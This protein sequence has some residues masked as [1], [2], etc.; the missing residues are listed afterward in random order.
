[1]GGSSMTTGWNYR[2]AWHD[3]ICKGPV[4][5]VIQFNGAEKVAWKGRRTSSGVSFINKPM[6]WGGDKDQGGAVGPLRWMF[7]E[8]GQMPNA[9]LVG[10]LGPE[11]PARR[12]ILTA[13]YEGGTWGAN[14]PY[15]QKRSYRVERI[16]AGWDGDDCWYPSTAAVPLDDLELDTLIAPNVMLDSMDSSIDGSDGGFDFELPEFCTLVIELGPGSDAWSFT[17][18]DD[19][20][21]E[22]YS[23]LTWSNRFGIANLTDPGIGGGVFWLDRYATAAAARAANG[24]ERVEIPITQAGTYRLY[25]YDATIDDNR[26]TGSYRVSFRSAGSRFAMN[27]AHMILFAHTQEDTGN[28]PRA[29]VNLD[30]L[31]AAA[32]W[33]YANGFGL[34]TERKPKDES[35][36]EFIQR[37][38]RVAGC[39]FSRSLVDGLFYLDVANGEYDLDSLPIITDKDVI[40]FKEFPTVLQDAV[41]SVS[42]R[43]RDPERNEDVITPPVRALALA[44]QYGEIHLTLDYLEIPIGN[45]AV[46]VA[47]RELLA[48]ITPTRLFELVCRPKVYGLRRSQYVRLQL[49]KRGI[50]DMVV[51]VGE[52]QAGSLSSGAIT[53]KLNQDV[54][55]LPTTVYTDVELGEDTSPPTEPADLDPQ[56]VMEAPYMTLAG[57]LPAAELAEIP[58][59]AG[60]VIGAAS[61]PGRMRDFTMA[62]SPPGGDFEEVGD[63]PFAP[64]A[65]LTGDIEPGLELGIGYTEGR[66]MAT[67]EVGDV[68]QIG[69]EIMRVDAHDPELHTLGLGRGCGD[70]IPAKHFEGDALIFFQRAAAYDPTQYFEG[71]HVLTKLLTNSWSERMPLADAPTVDVEMKDRQARPYNNGDMKLNGVS[72]FEVGQGTPGGGTGGPGGGGPTTPPATGTNGAPAS[73]ELGPLG[74]FPDN[75]PPLFPLPTVF[76]VDVVDDPA[77]D[78][79]ATLA[80][81]RK[82]DGSPLGPEWSLVEGKLKFQGGFGVHTAY[83]YSRR[84][85]MPYMPFPRLSIENNAKVQNSPGTKTE[86]GV[87]WGLYTTG[88]IPSYLEASEPLHY[89]DETEVTHTWLNEIRR[90]GSGPQFPG[91][92]PTLNFMQVVRHTVEYGFDTGTATVDDFDMIITKID[93][94][95]TPETPTNLDLSDGLTGITLWP[96]PTDTN[97]FVPDISVAGGVLTATFHSIYGFYRWIIFDDPLEHCDDADQFVRMRLKAWSNDPNTQANNTGKK[98]TTGGVTAGIAY[99]SPTGEINTVSAAGIPGRGDFTP[100]E[101]YHEGRVNASSGYTKHAAV[102]LVGSVGTQAKFKDFEV[103]ST[104]DSYPDTPP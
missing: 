81:W 70:T 79:P 69:G 77:F 57:Q 4:D 48:R 44:Q 59:G 51:I 65:R 7:G 104:N 27:P 98:Y 1:M 96:D 99:K 60:Y 40:S 74:G 20:Q 66:G 45:I 39:S 33:F 29:G 12:G 16:R 102:L 18:S 83:N 95:V 92:Y 43:Y 53:L 35:P 56:L 3:D 75:A 86:I 15:Q 103:A 85:G 97:E 90:S 21:P 17:P 50:A 91:E 73:T 64:S 32:D 34:C 25:L 41:N 46:R 101:Y 24:S 76:D 89:L 54:Y 78:D 28:Q 55:S 11:Q 93:P 47:E 71:E 67:I 58:D 100:R 94:E 38:E 49:P 80:R 22:N 37:I 5:A 26:G 52:I 19:Y 30:S 82:Q 14:N 8:A 87:A 42:V 61:D 31:N 72:I 62:T 88:Q 10:L 84:Y 68:L 9:Y 36:D 13:V 63:S 6:L 23:Y 2:L